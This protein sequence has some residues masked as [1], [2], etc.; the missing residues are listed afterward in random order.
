MAGIEFYLESLTDRIHLDSDGGGPFGLS[1][2]SGGFMMPPISNTFLEGAADGG[3]LRSSRVLMRPL[4]LGINVIASTREQMGVHVARLAKVLRQKSPLPRLVA[5]YA[6]GEVYN[7]PFRYQSGLEGDYSRYNGDVFNFI[8]SL[9]CP[10]PYWTSNT[11]LTISIPVTSSGRGLLP[12]LSQL[13]LENGAATGVITVENPGEVDSWPVWEVTGPGGPITIEL[14]D[15]GF[16]IDATL[17]GT[18]KRIIDTGSGTMVD[19]TGANAYAEF[20]PAPKLFPIPPG[21]SAISIFMDSPV[22]GESSIVGTYQP[23]KE[24]IV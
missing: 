9:M 4:D 20:A 23:R 6:N 7:L 18:D 10:N 11:S 14:G 8:L 1:A 19:E 15:V 16:T 22:A 5:E 17:A 24:V 21:L 13:Q 2:D 3:V 12:M